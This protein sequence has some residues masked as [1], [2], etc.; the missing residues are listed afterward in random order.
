MNLKNRLLQK[1]QLDNLSL[2]GKTLEQTLKSLSLINGIF[3]NHRYLAKSV[4]NYCK[5]NN[6]E[7]IK[8][9]DLGC[10]IGDSMNYLH[11]E[12]S[13]KGIRSTM[14]G[15]DGNPSTVEFATQKFGNSELQFITQD[16]L[17]PNFEIP[18]CNLLISSHFIY[19]FNDNE[20]Q[21]F[22]L[23]IKQNNCK[24]IILSELRRNHFAYILFSMASLVL[25]IS[26]LAK[27]DGLI[28]IRRAFTIEEI[29]TI[30]KPLK[31]NN[32]SIQK[33]P[34]FRMIVNISI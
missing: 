27:E 24:E 12:L 10:G 5:E 33:K 1:E 30:L 4:L 8:I 13:K 34:W 6:F 15:I 20:L 17:D 28:A 31:F 3:G 16:I 7:K 29:T 2:S 22:L 32:Y 14:I 9:I 11:S 25:P 18:D 21:S 19:H 23:K 26:K